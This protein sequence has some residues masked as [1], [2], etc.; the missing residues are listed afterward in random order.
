MSYYPK[1]QIKT[2]LYTAG[3]YRIPS[4][5]IEGYKGYYYETSSGKKYTGK[6]PG[7]GL[8]TLLTP[9]IPSGEVNPYD[10]SNYQPDTYII[11]NNVVVGDRAGDPDFD[12]NYTPLNQNLLP[13]SIPSFHYPKPTPQEI[14]QGAITR[15]FCKKNNEYKYIEINK[16]TFNKLQS[17]DKSIAWD[18]YTPT[19]LT[20][21]LNSRSFYLSP[22]IIESRLG[23]IGFSKYAKLLK[24][25]TEGSRTTGNIANPSSPSNINDLYTSGDEF[26]T[27]NGQNYVGFYHVH[28]NTTPMVGKTHT[29]APHETLIPVSGKT[30]LQ[31]VTKYLS[32]PENLPT[33]LQNNTNTSY[34]QPDTTENMGSSG[35]GMSS[36]G[37]Y[38]GGGGGGY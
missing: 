36:G 23:W 19:S 7:D 29:D 16:D 18:L 32:N 14:Q 1:S 22:S 25:Y 21:N 8:N 9:N 24:V 2:N 37:G 3:K 33:F 20:Y 30:L 12:H 4:S 35:G 10:L 28:K 17:Q 34:S 27:Q 15:Y 38:S 11:V 6:F 5:P 13:R 26:T 31:I